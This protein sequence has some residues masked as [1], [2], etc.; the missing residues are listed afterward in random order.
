MKKAIDLG[1]IYTGRSFIIFYLLYMNFE[2]AVKITKS[3]LLLLNKNYY[4]DTSHFG[5]IIFDLINV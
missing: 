2:E 1:A 5:I 3:L 4:V